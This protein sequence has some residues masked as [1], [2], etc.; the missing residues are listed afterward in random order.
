MSDVPVFKII[1]PNNAPLGHYPSFGD[2]RKAAEAMLSDGRAKE[3]RIEWTVGD[4]VR[5]RPVLTGVAEIEEITQELLGERPVSRF[6]YGKFRPAMLGAVIVAAVA[7][8]AWALYSA[9]DIVIH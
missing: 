2:A 8:L 7:L 4:Q 5:Q 3:A 1:G 6:D 9:L